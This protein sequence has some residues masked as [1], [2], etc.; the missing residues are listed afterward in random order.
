MTRR[1]YFVELGEREVPVD[2]ERLA[3]GRFRVLVAGEEKP[4]ELSVLHAGPRAAVLSERR[5]LEL[6]GATPRELTAGHTRTR[7]S[8]TER[9]VSSAREHGGS[10]GD[11]A[12][13]APM[14]GRVLK[15]LVA[16]GQA[17]KSGERV[18]V[19]EAMKMENELLAQRA[20]TVK[21][22]LVREGDTVERNAVLLELE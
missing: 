21:R 2:V 16:P 12:V 7:L 15:L 8:V 18:A 5:V 10:A 9:S 14:P 11:T 20:G 3:D 22:V 19:V 1:R 6:F 17:V 13:R 4:R